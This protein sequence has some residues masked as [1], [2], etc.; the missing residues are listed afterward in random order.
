MSVAA[1]RR[2]A[3]VHW[4]ARGHGTPSYH[5]KRAVGGVGLNLATIIEGHPDDAVA[6]VHEGDEVSFGALRARVGVARRVLVD[7]G[8]ERGDRVAVVAPNR[9]ETVVA[10]MAVLGVGAVA[11]P[12]NPQS[13]ATELGREL[14]VVAPLGVVGDAAGL[15]DDLPRLDVARGGDVADIPEIVDVDAGDAA[16]LM[17]TSGTAG[18]SHAAVLSHGNLFANLDQVD[19]MAEMRR[20]SDD[21]T[22]G[23]LPL[24]HVF[25]LN[26]VLAPTLR[27]GGRAVLVDGFDASATVE[28]VTHHRVT[29]LTGPPT[30]WGALAAL[31][32]AAASHDAFSSVRL[33]AS[34][35]APLPVATATRIRDRFGVVV[36]E[37]YG[38]TE[39]S[40]VVATSV[41]T[42]APPG[43]IGRPLPGVEVRLLD[44]HEDDVL[45]GDV[46]HLHVRGP[47]V[48]GGYWQ[49]AD[50]TAAVF[51]AEGWLRT[52]DL[53]VVDDDGYL[54]LVDR[55]KDLVIVSGF[56]V[57]PAEVEEVLAS[58]PSVADVAVHGV[59]DERT[60]ETVVADVVPSSSAPADDAAWF[61]LLDA[62]VG[63]HLSRYK[64]PTGYHRVDHI[65]RGLGGKVQRRLL[66][67]AE[68]GSA[69]GAPSVT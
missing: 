19:A 10:L 23:I 32:D 47:N 4:R 48:F 22:L 57:F 44:A 15:P 13:P 40:P 64:C 6:L 1:A 20:R 51:T 54:F 3:V 53:A 55:A 27:A 31:D 43:S 62:H 49:D 46:G 45:V 2:P 26:V 14:G 7:A 37:G 12:L 33:A 25:G 30:M 61:A 8:V 67:G 29:L 59:A 35:A 41:G 42:D 36:H 63:T 16:V 24:F 28:L 58:H 11:V 39:A 5:A 50:A 60:G 21:I 18:A 66:P 34:G 69:E 68:D 38:L 17:F 56:N 9:P 65:P 52:G